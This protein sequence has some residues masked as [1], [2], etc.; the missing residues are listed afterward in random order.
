MALIKCPEC[1]QK[2]S[3]LSITCP[4]CS[5][6]I[7]GNIKQCPHCG[8]WTQTSKEACVECGKEISKQSTSDVSVSEKNNVT[9]NIQTQQE[10]PT[11]TNNTN[12]TKISKKPK[13]KN[14]CIIAL[15]CF[16]ILMI[17]IGAAGFGLY[18]YLEIQK[19]EKKAIQEELIKRIEENKKAN[20]ERLL[21]MQQDS[22]FWQKTFKAKTIEE[23]EAYINAYP[24]G[25]FI[26]EA[27]MLLEELKRRKVSSSE[28]SLIRVA[29]E[30]ELED[31]RKRRMR[32]KESDVLGIHPQISDKLNITKKYINRDSFKYVVRGNVT[33]TINRTNPKKPHNQDIKMVLTMDSDRNII[34]S[35]LE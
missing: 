32:K 4:N 18:K 35:N 29:V 22:T 9:E 30:K 25:I 2:V 11:K 34:E 20:A 14:G 23:T 19:A 21:L 8:E 16:S 6:R 28:E 12:D 7:K 15:V 17:C 33:V 5:T 13:K 3:S 1:G 24:E 31:Y 27:Y 26:N 10:Q